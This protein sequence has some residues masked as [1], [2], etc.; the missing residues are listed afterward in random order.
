MT[1]NFQRQ[2][3]TTQFDSYFIKPQSYRL[4]AGQ[5]LWFASILYLESRVVKFGN[6]TLYL[7]V[8]TNLLVFS[9]Y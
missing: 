5:P 7:F 3:P 8:V 1:L 2:Y 9:F 4:Q 6:F